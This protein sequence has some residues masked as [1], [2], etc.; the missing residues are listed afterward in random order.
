MKRGKREVE[1]EK[2]EGIEVIEK[3][4]KREEICVELVLLYHL[5]HS[6]NFS[7]HPQF[8]IYKTSSSIL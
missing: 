3:K 7:Y 4:R 2:N 8:N 6:L 5:S 1:F